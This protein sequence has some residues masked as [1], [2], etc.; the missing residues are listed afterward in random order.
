M[1]QRNKFSWILVFLTV[2]ALG[3]IM[4]PVIPVK[5]Q[6]DWYVDGSSGTNDGSHGTGPSSLAFKTIQ[7][8]INDSRVSAGDTIKVAPGTYNESIVVNKSLI[9]LGAQADVDPRPSLG[10]RSGPESIIESSGTVLSIQAHNVVINGFTFKSNINN[11]TL[12]V[13]EAVDQ[14][15]PQIIYNI[16]YNTNPGG[17]SNE[18]KLRFG[19]CSLI[20]LRLR[21]P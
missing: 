20:Q 3:A 14:Q 15:H 18:E 12:N 13:V 21:H 17:S 7:Y 8:A 4:V 19:R 9:L 5:A 6:T 16:V 11:S 10:V 2:L 1:A